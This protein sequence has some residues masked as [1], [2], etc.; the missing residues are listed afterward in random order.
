MDSS[1]ESADHDVSSDK[2]QQEANP[3]SDTSMSQE[4]D[5]DTK[6]NLSEP[7]EAKSIPSIE[8]Q[9]EMGDSNATVRA[10]VLPNSIPLEEH[11]QSS[12]TLSQEL[13]PL[14]SGQDSLSIREKVSQDGYN[15]RKYGQKNV[16]RIELIRSYYR[17]THL[18]C[19]AKKKLHLLN[20]GSFAGYTFVGE[21]NH[22]GPQSNTVSSPV[23]RVLPVVEQGSHSRSSLAGVEG[24]DKS[25]GEDERRPQQVKPLHSV[26]ASKVSGT[27]ELKAA[28][29]QLAAKGEVHKYENREAKRLKKDNSNTDTNGVGVST[30]ESGVV[31]VETE[32]EVDFVNDGHR[33]RKY[34]QKMV[35]GNTNPRHYYR[36][37]YL[38]CPAKRRIER[39]PREPKNV[40]STYEGQHDHENPAER[41]VTHNTAKNTQTKGI[42]GKMKTQSGGNTVYAETGECSYSHSKSWLN[43]ESNSKPNYDSIFRAVVLPDIG[44]KCELNEEEQ[45]NEDPSTKEDSVSNAMM[46]DPSS[47]VPSRSNEHV[48]D[49]VRTT[50]E[51]INDCSNV[52]TGHDTSSTTSEFDKESTSDTEPF[53]S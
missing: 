31:V 53:Q 40:I 13:P 21:H 24:Q 15:W 16:K 34:G 29:S 47:E 45:Q 52:V 38:G 1:Q 50:S 17:C 37:S 48:E 7:E 12:N 41:G 14:R 19:Q 46:L 2:V 8:A 18:D 42:N 9:N 26:P 35:K 22:A 3:Q 30:G 28:Q 44:L 20:D 39:S 11:S 23:D 36:C 32:S 49:E 5:D 25:S 43:K 4:I 10:L 6:T 33:W 27:D 51:G